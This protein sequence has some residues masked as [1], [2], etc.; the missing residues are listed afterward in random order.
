MF[1]PPLDDLI[2][3]VRAV[4]PAEQQVYL[5]GGAVRD[6]LLGVPLNDL[7]FVLTGDVLA[8]S[9]RL[10]NRLNAAYYPLDAE[11]ETARLI[12]P[13]PDGGRMKLD[14]AACRASDLESDLRARDLT[15]NSIALE[16]KDAPRIIDP[17]GGIADIKNK[18]LRACSEQSFQDDPVRVLRCVRLAASLGYQ[19]LPETS[20]LIRQAT[21]YLSRVSPE[22]LRDELFRILDGSQPATAM[23]LLDIL[24]I[25]PQMLP[26]V[27]A[28]KGVRQSPPHVADVWNH[29]LDVIQRLGR[30]L[31]V[32]SLDYDQEKAASWALGY[33]SVRLGRYRQ[34]LDQHLTTSLNPDRSLRALLV[35]SALYH[36]VG[37]PETSSVDET[38][39][40]RFFEHEEAGRMLAQERAQAFRLSNDEISRLCIIIRHHMRPL[41]LAKVAA[42]P[43]RRSIYR[44]F[45]ATSAA[46]IDIA[47]LSLADT[48][49]VYGD[50]L[51][52]ETWIRQVDVI[53]DLME[54]WWNHPTES[55]APPA[56]LDGNDLID[57]FGL[58]PGPIIGQL[59]EALRESQAA[60]QVD[61]RSQAV[62]FIHR[63]I[64]K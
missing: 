63:Q 8:T 9:R 30:V 55:I 58:S 47:L 32:L 28:M 4:I 62:D 19:I 35:L 24:D 36:D 16:L 54:A 15:V 34:Q 64:R 43:S 29:T 33:I 2:R 20:R 6:L 59:L 5:V 31:D 23:R 13:Q 41:L 21:G 10:A 7:D 22:R 49:A 48:L 18:V 56:L 45:R 26:E 57:I 14:F 11:R 3:K 61:N 1:P 44:Y 27:W 46:G 17:L 40:V 39:R 25:L 50:T 42:G 53:H 52:R 38:Q 51:P 60:G 37:K 12:L